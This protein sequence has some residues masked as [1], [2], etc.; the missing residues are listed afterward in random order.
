MVSTDYFLTFALYS[1]CYKDGF[2]VQITKE[3]FG[4]ISFRGAH[5]FDFEYSLKCE[6]AVG[7]VPP[8]RTL[9]R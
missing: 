7:W 5:N 3:T 4:Y 2:K 9:G 1:E 6:Y 8:H